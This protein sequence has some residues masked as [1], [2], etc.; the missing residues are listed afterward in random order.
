MT[1]KNTFFGN[2]YMP[3]K[4]VIQMQLNVTNLKVAY[5]YQQQDDSKITFLW[6]A[7]CY[8]STQLPSRSLVI[9][10]IESDQEKV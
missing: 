3:F 8:S 5:S 2:D 4:P 1:E 7:F 6:E 10:K 9:F